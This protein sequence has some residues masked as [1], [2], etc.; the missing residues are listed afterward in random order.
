MT[1]IESIDQLGISGKRPS[2]LEPK[3]NGSKPRFNE[4][5]GLR[6]RYIDQRD[7][8]REDYEFEKG[9]EECTFRPNLRDNLRNQ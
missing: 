1:T 3:A 2:E 5:Y 4:L 7:K 8:S 9:Q 6:K